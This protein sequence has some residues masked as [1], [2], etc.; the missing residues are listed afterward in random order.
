MTAERKLLDAERVDDYLA[1]VADRYRLRIQQELTPRDAEQ[2][3]RFIA[4]LETI[5][6]YVSEMVPDAPLPSEGAMSGG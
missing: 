6:R 4:D 1:S 5:R 2:W 3:R